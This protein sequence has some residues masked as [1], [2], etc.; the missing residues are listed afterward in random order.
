MNTDI[1]LKFRALAAIMHA[2]GGL[3]PIISIPI[4]WIL[5]ITTKEL[6]P[7]IDRCGRSALNFQASVILYLTVAILLLFTTCG[8]LSNLG[9][10]GQSAMIMMGYP[11]FF[12]TPILFAILFVIPI[13]AA[14]LAILGKVYSYPLTIKFVSEEQ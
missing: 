2:L 7:F 5:W 1:P 11:V 9:Q 3:A 10:F 13:A 8:I 4:T 12:V 14:I 6:H